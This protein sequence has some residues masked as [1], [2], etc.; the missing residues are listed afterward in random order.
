[1]CELLMDLEII[2]LKK[3]ADAVT[4]LMVASNFVVSSDLDIKAISL[5][6]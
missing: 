6:S 3:L 4:L 2:L 5:L 1:M